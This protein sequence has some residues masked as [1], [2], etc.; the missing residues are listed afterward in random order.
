MKRRGA[1]A[2]TVLGGNAETLMDCQPTKNKK[3]NEL[4][5]KCAKDCYK[6]FFKSTKLDY[7][8]CDIGIGYDGIR[9]GIEPTYMYEPL[10][11][12]TI[13]EDKG[14]SMYSTGYAYGA[15]ASSINRTDRYYKNGKT[16]SKFIRFID[17]WHPLFYATL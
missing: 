17:K 5:K 11:M 4:L 13:N 15:W 3:K 2:M 12:I 1:A 9:I 7:K 10:K 6:T 16:K 8:G 14:M